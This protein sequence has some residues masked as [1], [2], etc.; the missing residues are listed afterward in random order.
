MVI[1]LASDHAG[2]ALKEQIKAALQERTKFEA[3]RDMGTYSD[4]AVD[5]PD[6]IHFA[7]QKM[8]EEPESCAIFLCGSGNG[9]CMTANRYP[10]MRAALAW[11]AEIAKLARQHNDANVLCLP[12]RFISLAE[13]LSCVEAFLSTPFEG[14]RHQIRVA[15][16][17]P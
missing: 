13:A 8:K 9:V 16:I 3:L 5:Y 17:N 4:A 7:A 15:K 2:Y 14:G 1:F 10:H 6:I 11:N 12:A